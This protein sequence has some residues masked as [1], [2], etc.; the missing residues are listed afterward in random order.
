MPL[1]LSVFGGAGTANLQML[2]VGA[3][4]FLRWL[5]GFHRR[6]RATLVVH[7]KP[8][9]SAALRQRSRIEPG[10]ACHLPQPIERV[11]LA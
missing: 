11:A 9:T 2:Y 10:W 7:G 1:S 8:A 6:P 3:D 5:V 4:K